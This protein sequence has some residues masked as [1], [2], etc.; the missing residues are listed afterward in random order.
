MQVRVV[1]FAIPTSGDPEF[2]GAPYAYQTATTDSNGIALP[3]EPAK[4]VVCVANGAVS[5]SGTSGTTDHLTGSLG[6]AACDIFGNEASGYCAVNYSKDNVSTTVAKRRTVARSNFIPHPED[7]AGTFG[8]YADTC[9][10]RAVDG[11]VQLEWNPVAT[12]RGGTI[13]LWIVYGAEVQVAIGTGTTP[14][15]TA[16]PITY[17]CRDINSATNETFSPTAIFL[18]AGDITSAVPWQG[19][20]DAAQSIAYDNDAAMSF[21]MGTADPEGANLAFRSLAWRDTNGAGT[22]A[23]GSYFSDDYVV[24]GEVSNAGAVASPILFDSVSDTGF[25]LD[26]RL[27]VTNFN[28]AYLAL[29]SVSTEIKLETFTT[30]SATGYANQGI[31]SPLG[32]PQG[33]LMIQGQTPS[34]SVDTAMTNPVSATWGIGMGHQVNLSNEPV[35]YS[36]GFQ[37]EDNSGTSDTQSSWAAQL[38]YLVKKHGASATVSDFDW[39]THA[40]GSA[41]AASV[42]WVTNTTATGVVN[43]QWAGLFVG[44]GQAIYQS[45]N[46]NNAV[47][48]V[49]V[50]VIAVPSLVTQTGPPQSIT[51]TSTDKVTTTGAHPA[52]AGLSSCVQSST[53][54]VQVF[55]LHKPDASAARV[56]H[57]PRQEIQVATSTGDALAGTSRTEPMAASVVSDAVAGWSR[58]EPVAA[59]AV[60]DLVG[61]Q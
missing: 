3:S 9:T 56:V 58:T 40:A 21:G 30:P 11:S 7:T 17:E 45:Q 52:F 34:G 61:S 50:N 44:Y 29:R 35:T 22:S 38:G 16:A 24:V 51:L 18:L 31:G 53:P 43:R 6:F 13:V 15:N 25:T 26:L 20:E 10:I 4:A 32:N 33:V 57:S 60:L 55:N 14:N 54:S 23:S 47:P 27:G 2:G 59:T 46:N 36:V 12:G 41:D 1:K 48:A 39:A 5:T 28:F 37:V 49:G 19:T 8:Y 42:D